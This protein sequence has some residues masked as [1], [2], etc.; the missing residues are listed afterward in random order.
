MRSRVNN[1]AWDGP[2][3]NLIDGTRIVPK[4]ITFAPEVVECVYRNGPFFKVAAG[5]RTSYR[6]KTAPP[7]PATVRGFVLDRRFKYS[8]R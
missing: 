1:T 6:V 5:S 3:Y 8:L 4:L 7:A 2:R